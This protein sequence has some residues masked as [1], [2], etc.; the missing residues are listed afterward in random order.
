MTGAD[1]SP[2]KELQD[3]QGGLIGFNKDHQQLHYINFADGPSAKALIVELIPQLA[4]GFEVLHFNAAYGDNLL[5]RGD[6]DA[7]QATWVNLWLSRS[8][9]ALLGAPD[10]DSMPADF[11]E[12]MPSRNVGDVG[13]SA[14]DKWVAPFTAGAEPHAVIVIAS[15]N[16]ADIETRRGRVFDL[17]SRHGGTVIGTQLGDARPGAMRGHEHFGFKDGISQPGIEHFTKSSKSGSI[18]PGEVLIGYP[19]ADGNI[20]GQPTT[21]PTPAPTP[22]DPAPTPPPAQPLPPWTHNGSFVVLRRLRQDVAA[23]QA[24]MAN[25]AATAN[26]TAEQLTAKLFGRWPSGAPM[27]H[28]PGMPHNLDPSTADPS[29]EFP[30]AL[31]NNKIN[32]FDFSDDHDGVRVPHAAHIRKTNPRAD[33]LADGDSST[34]HRMLRRGITYGPEFAPG[35]TPYG[36]I[37]PDTQDRGLLFVNYQ[38]SISRTFEFVQTRWANRDD[39]QQAGDGKD[40]IISQDTPDGAFSLPPDRSLTFARWVTTTGGAYLFSPALSALVQLSQ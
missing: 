26:L 15:D 32:N 20:S 10:L 14:P 29:A 36:E 8:G 33:S 6:P 18:P 1:F 3:I 16:L 35:E 21:T 31:T 24:A 30:E 40:P 27:E 5:R 17:V 25:Q 12:G 4:N 9:L 34:R 23:F 39:F 28:V 38:A 11:R 2:T 7:L 19:N 13:A 22:Y 37:V